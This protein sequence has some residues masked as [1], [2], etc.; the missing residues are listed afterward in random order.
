MAASIVISRQNGKVEGET[1][2]VNETIVGTVHIISNLKRSQN[3]GNVHAVTKKRLEVSILKVLILASLELFCLKEKQHNRHDLP[4]AK[5][6]WFN[7]SK[8]RF[9]N[10]FILHKH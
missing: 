10:N 7:W 5:L 3:L 1:H 8:Q 9:R 4:R 6:P 2:P